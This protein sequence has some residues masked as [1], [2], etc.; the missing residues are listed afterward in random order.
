M[1]PLHRAGEGLGGFSKMFF[2]FF[3]VS[4]PPFISSYQRRDKAYGTVL[5]CLLGLD[6]VGLVLGGKGAS[7]SF[8]WPFHTFP[9]HFSFTFNYLWSWS[10]LYFTLL[11]A[12]CSMLYALCSMLYALCS[13]LYALC[14]MLYALCSMLYGSWKFTSFDSCMDG[15]GLQSHRGR[16]R[17]SGS[18]RGQ[19]V[20]ARVGVEGG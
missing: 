7:S 4:F 17:G 9:S 3:F 10:I 20:G 8:L 12:L 11:Y 13:M 19:L 15:S 18:G 5:A 14:S 16:G 6:C 2:L 1:F